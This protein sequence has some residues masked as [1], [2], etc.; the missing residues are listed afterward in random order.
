MNPVIRNIL[1]LFVGIVI[2]G[3]VNLGLITVGMSVIPLPEGMDVSTMESLR[4]NMKLLGP[5]NFIFPL[6]G[7]ALGTFTGAFLAAKLAANHRM[8]FAIGVGLF[9][10]LGG[11]GMI[12]NCGGPLWFIVTDLVL[13]YI[14]M[15]YL[16]GLLGQSNKAQPV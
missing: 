5:V 1:A 16:G 8:K 14:P 4:A 2:G 10:L 6:L 12:L 13:A 7:H 15:A 3:V 9:F 11:I